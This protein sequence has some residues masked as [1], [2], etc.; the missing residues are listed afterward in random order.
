[1]NKSTKDGEVESKKEQEDMQ[2]KKVY[3]IKK[4]I[5]SHQE[6]SDP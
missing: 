1:M 2:S 4:G 3:A 6:R 5:E